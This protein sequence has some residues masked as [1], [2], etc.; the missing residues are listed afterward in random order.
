MILGTVQMSLASIKVSELF[1]SE[2]KLFTAE[3][4]SEKLVR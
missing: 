4:C 3:K 2:G 1:P